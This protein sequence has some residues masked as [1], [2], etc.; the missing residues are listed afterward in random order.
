MAKAFMDQDFLLDS[1]VARE[2]Y[3]GTAAKLPIIDYHCHIPPR[4]IAQNSVFP[5]LTK[6][7]LAADHYKWRAMRACGV[8]ERLITGEADD[9]EKFRAWAA[10]MPQLVGNPLY[11]WSHLELQRYIGIDMPLSPATA[12]EIWT[13]GKKALARLSARR[14]MELSGVER[15]CTTDDPADT[16]E[17]HQIIR[18]DTSFATQV[19]PAF[20][21]DRALAVE[22]PDFAAYIGTLAAAAEIPVVTIDDLKAALSRR[23][24][25]FAEAGCCAADHGLTVFPFVEDQAAARAAF[26][27]AMEGKLPSAA[28]AEAFRTELLLWLAREYNR[29]GWVMEIHF[30]VLRNTRTDQLVRLG[31]DAGFDNMGQPACISSLTRFLDTL[32]TEG[33]LPKTLLFS[34]NPAD[35]AP[36]CTLCGAFGATV[37]PGSAWWF[38]DTL[39]GM[40]EQLAVYAS[41]LPLGRFLGFLTDSRSLL[42]YTRHEYFRRLL[43]GWLGERVE[44]G[45]YPFDRTA[46]ETLAADIAYHNCRRF[47]AWTDKEKG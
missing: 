9:E 5:N 16:L 42:S 26:E 20:R 18:E 30:G 23:M 46:L 24:D 36:L 4:E 32:A 14:I 7:W 22:K 8:E 40:R 45:E 39:H 34:I 37:Q 43:C 10:C 11:H 29:R 31:A 25:A 6:A 47:F 28:Q 15:L 13:Q 33:V 35:N 19:V 2:L 21:P 44:R 38:N 17:Y 1:P 12:D 41:L 27:Q 3:H